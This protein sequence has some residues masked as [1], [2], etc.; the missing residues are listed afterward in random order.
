VC[1]DGKRTPPEVC[2]DG[3]ANGT[4]PG[5]CNPGCTGKVESKHLRLTP[6]FF[7]GNLGGVSGADAK[8]V[9]A[10]G[11]G[12]KALI[13]DPGK[14]QA[15]RTQADHLS[16]TGI[17]AID[18]IDWVL[19]PFTRYLNS[20]DEEVW[21]TDESAMLGVRNQKFEAFLPHKLNPDTF[22][23][24]WAGCF[25]DWHPFFYTCQGW[26]SSSSAESGTVYSNDAT[27]R[28]FGDDRTV[29]LSTCDDRLHVVCVEP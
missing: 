4:K 6:Q 19:S 12:W 7:T 15:T 25:Y 18:P 23:Y 17:E 20:K 13:S 14:R 16:G 5:Q 29:G 27:T 21:T 2:D 1:G 10:F 22:K 24:S 3:P 26:T 9:A 11:A 8:C 28:I